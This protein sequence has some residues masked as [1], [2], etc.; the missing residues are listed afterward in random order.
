MNIKKIVLIGISIL[1]VV[2]AAIFLRSQKKSV[3]NLPVA[4]EYLRSVDVVRVKKEKISQKKEFL[5]Q[6]LSSKSA[7]IATKFVAKIKKIYVNEN[8]KVKKGDLLISLDDKDILANLS[9][10]K[11]QKKALSLDAQNAKNILKT[12]TKLYK[13]GAISKEAYDKT[14]AIYL[15]KL[16]SLKTVEEKINQTKAN[17]QYLNLTAPF[18][19]VIGSK[20]LDV[21]SLA[22]AGK[23]ILSLNSDDQ[24][25][26]FL[27]SQNDKKITKGQKVFLEDKEIG[28]VLKIYDD[29]KNSLLVA[30]VKLKKSLPFANKSYKTIQVETDSVLSCTLPTNA[31]LHKKDGNFIMIYKDEKFVAKKIKILL[32]NPKRVAISS[33][34]K[35]LVAVG[36]EAKLSILPTFGKIIVDKV[37]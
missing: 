29:A 27:F 32:E 3:D 26:I 36:S 8:D 22:P 31:I 6:I 21:G 4:K 34:P 1:V 11:E 30:E 23:P 35:E 37:K 33:C 10:L 13:I 20:F 19:G 9:S 24:K 18:D 15:T 2:S 17:L 28:R 16:S 25:L 5:A 7:N 12:N 14:K